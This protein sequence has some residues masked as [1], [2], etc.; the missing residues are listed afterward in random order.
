MFRNVVIAH[1]IPSAPALISFGREYITENG[2]KP[3]D[4]STFVRKSDYILS[5]LRSYVLPNVFIDDDGAQI[6]QPFISSSSGDQGTI[7]LLHPYVIFK[8]ELEDIGITSKSYKVYGQSV[9][10]L[11]TQYPAYFDLMNKDN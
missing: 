8:H 10:G 7:E 4:I 9:D 5:N 6:E 11:N 1:N 3:T 2:K